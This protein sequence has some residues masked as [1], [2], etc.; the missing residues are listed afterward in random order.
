MW[1]LNHVAPSS[2]TYLWGFLDNVWI[3]AV[4][5]G[6]RNL[7]MWA[8]I[9]AAATHLFFFFFFFCL[10]Y[11]GELNYLKKK[12][13]RQSSSLFFTTRLFAVFLR[14]RCLATKCARSCGACV[15][16]CVFVCVCVCVCVRQREGWAAAIPGHP[17]KLC[18]SPSTCSGNV[19]DNKH[20]A[21]L[22]S[23][24]Q[25]DKYQQKRKKK[26]KKRKKK[27]KSESN[28]KDEEVCS[29]AKR[30]HSVSSAS[31]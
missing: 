27:K 2:E 13:K 1:R 23:C 3:F 31:H 17:F 7:L 22:C 4:F 20:T 24:R 10:A 9:N 25:L 21:V 11:W 16:V 6:C 15:S 28:V 30:S 18:T 5:L 14:Y 19:S 29:F 12:E 8:Q 26:E